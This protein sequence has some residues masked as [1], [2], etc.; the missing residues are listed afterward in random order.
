[1]AVAAV[2]LAVSKH[3][4]DSEMM[5]A[6]GQWDHHPG[7][8]GTAGLRADGQMAQQ[9]NGHMDAMMPSGL[10]GR[11]PEVRLPSSAMS[12]AGEV[13]SEPSEAPSRVQPSV[14]GRE[15]RHPC[16]CPPLLN[17]LANPYTSVQK[18]QICS[19]LVMLSQPPPIPLFITACVRGVFGGSISMNLQCNC[20]RMSSTSLELLWAGCPVP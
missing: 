8:H 11:R 19:A 18:P 17:P 2:W 1:M 3:V 16:P 7:S 5:P 4:L 9:Q 13:D 14:Q 6:A 10:P 20:F 15:V 12:D